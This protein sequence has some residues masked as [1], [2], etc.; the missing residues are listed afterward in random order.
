MSLFPRQHVVGAF[1]G[2]SEGGM[3]FHADL[4]LPYRSD[5]QSS[6]MHGQFMLVQLEHDREAVLG[7]ITTIAAQGRLVSPSGEDYAVRAIHEGLRL[8]P[9]W[10]VRDFRPRFELYVAEPDDWI[11]HRRRLDDAVKRQ[12]RDADYAFLRA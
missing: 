8:D 5:F 10:P 2:F 9:D 6:P 4:V 3:E 1:R 12:P 7:R 11:E